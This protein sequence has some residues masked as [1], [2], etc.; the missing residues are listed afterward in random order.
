M[1]PL[2]RS[3][4]RRGGGCSGL[5]A[6]WRLSAR[7]GLGSERHVGLRQEAAAAVRRRR[8]L[9]SQLLPGGAEPPPPPHG[10]RR[11]LPP[12]PRAARAGRAATGGRREGRRRWPPQRRAGLGD[13]AP[14]APWALSHRP[15]ALNRVSHRAVPLRTAV[16]EPCPPQAGCDRALSPSGWLSQ[17]PV[18]LRL[19]WGLVP[20]RQAVTGPCLP[21][22][23]HRRVLSPSGLHACPPQAGCYRAVSP[24]GKL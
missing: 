11:Q 19:P 18:P 4:S 9:P 14:C 21:Q 13:A 7:P 15:G 5:P 24:S 8:L 20:L 6:G 17:G 22:D 2:P 23:S 16:A 10:P 12:P 1:P 3:W